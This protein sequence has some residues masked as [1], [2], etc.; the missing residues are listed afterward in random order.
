MRRYM[1]LMEYALGRMTR[2]SGFL[3]GIGMVM[4]IALVFGNMSAR[5]LFGTGAVWL[6]ELEWYLLAFTAMTGIAYAM[7]FDDHVRIDVFSHKLARV[8]RKWLN[9]VTM[10]LIAVPASI[11]I[12]YYAWP[13][14]M[15][16]WARSEGS[17]NRGGMPWL[18]I[19]KSMILVGFILILSES[20]RQI[21]RDVR[22]LLFY[23]SKRRNNHAA[24]YKDA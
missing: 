9:I 8:P 19:P 3:S 24:V 23:Y 11:L 17:P 20:I 10:I 13:Y 12:L 18:F 14:M 4:L 2:L 5:Y 21:M 15:V 16:S 22:Q 7:R 6:Q 1:F